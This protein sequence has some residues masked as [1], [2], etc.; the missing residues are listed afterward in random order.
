M[1]LE[2]LGIANY[3]NYD[4]TVL[5]FSQG[6]NNFL[7]LNGMGKTNLLDAIYYLCLCKSHFGITDIDVVKKE[8]DFLRLEGKFMLDGKREK[9]VAKVQPRKKKIF[10]RN[11]SP[12][13]SLIEH[14]GTFP[15]IIVSPDD[16][17]LATGSSEERRKFIDNT[18]SQLD[19][20]Y[21]SSLILYNKIIAQRN[22][23]LKKAALE[24]AASTDTHQILDIYDQQIQEPATYIHQKRAEYIL[25]FSDVFNAVYST[26]SDDKEKVAC[27]YESQLTNHQL[28]DLLLK[29]RTRDLY[30][31][32]TTSG[33]HKDDL[34][35]TINN[36]PLKKFASQGQLKTYVLSL[37][38]AQYKTLQAEKNK[39]PLLLLD[40]IFDKLDENRVSNLLKYIGN[41]TFGQ[42]F[43]SDTH[44]ERLPRI[45]TQANLINKTF[46]VENGTCTETPIG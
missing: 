15:C 42:V 46:V 20:H 13:T 7:G 4:H 26:I 28:P 30:L 17:L 12:Y 39:N 11:D 33:T 40:D 24:N 10:E 35:F 36:S 38:L 23:L 21:L 6:F 1:Y 41:G 14:I 22:A 27:H 45:L 19:S 16:T 3:R 34:T 2:R 5:T 37:K 18:L 31:Q 43:L 25:K 9:I 29:N 32:R 44:P 8:T